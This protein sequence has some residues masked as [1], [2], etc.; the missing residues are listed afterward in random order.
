MLS[1]CIFNQHHSNLSLVCP[2][3]ECDM[4]SGNLRPYKHV[5][6][7]QKLGHQVNLHIKEEGL[8]LEKDS[9]P[10]GTDL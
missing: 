9:P 8:K 3:T 5:S 7:V 6:V 2:G 1:Q 4:L 10:L